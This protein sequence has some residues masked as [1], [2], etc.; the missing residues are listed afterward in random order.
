MLYLAENATTTLLEVQFAASSGG[1]FQAEPKDPYVIFSI[2][3]RLQQLV[4]LHNPESLADLGLTAD[5]LQK[6]WR[7]RQAREGSYA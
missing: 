1:R 4:D 2:A 7:L 3:F 5:E 6:P